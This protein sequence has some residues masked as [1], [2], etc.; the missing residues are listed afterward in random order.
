[1]YD[2]VNADNTAIML[3]TI[4]SSEIMQYMPSEHSYMHVQACLASSL[5][6]LLEVSLRSTAPASEYAREL[7][8]CIIMVFKV[9]KLK[10]CLYWYHY[11]LLTSNL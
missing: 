5:I 10:I 6:I 4:A 9:N 2:K 11:P 3:A 8:P 1:M 7:R